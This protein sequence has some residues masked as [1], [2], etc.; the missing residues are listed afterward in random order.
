MVCRCV[1]YTVTALYQ[2]KM[3]LAAAKEI[4]GLKPPDKVKL[5]A[6]AVPISSGSIDFADQVSCQWDNYGFW[7]PS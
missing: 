1:S 4:I 7:P 2:I 3:G 5:I 6:I